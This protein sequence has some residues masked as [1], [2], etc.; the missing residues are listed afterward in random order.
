MCYESLVDGRAQEE[1]TRRL[2]R[3]ERWDAFV[4]GLEAAVLVFV[5]LLWQGT[6]LPLLVGATVAAVA[7]GYVLHQVVLVAGVSVVRRVGRPGS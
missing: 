2:L 4:N 3:G 5:V 7:L 6:E 1:S